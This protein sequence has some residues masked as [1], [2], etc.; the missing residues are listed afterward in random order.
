MPKG[1]IVSLSIR[2]IYYNNGKNNPKRIIGNFLVIKLYW[3][4]IG[5]R[6]NFELLIRIDWQVFTDL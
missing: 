5:F 4:G 2:L 1:K 6:E 3:R